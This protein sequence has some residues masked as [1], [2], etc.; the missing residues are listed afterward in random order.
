VVVPSEFQV[1]DRLC[2]MLC[3]RAGYR[4]ADQIDIDLPQRRLA[5][6]AKDRRIV[7]LDLMPH[8]RASKAP[9]YNSDAAQLNEHGNALTATIL[10]EWLQTQFGATLLASGS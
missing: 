10:S 6:Y 2:R 1:D 4:Q 9:T 7:M 3:R 5:A 8:M